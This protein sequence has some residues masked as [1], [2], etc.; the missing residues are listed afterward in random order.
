MRIALLAGFCFAGLFTSVMTFADASPALVFC[1]KPENDLARV[2]AECGIAFTRYDTPGQT[3]FSAP[4]HAGV[5]FL[6]DEYPAKTVF[7]APECF[8]TAAQK[9]LRLY[10]EYPAALPDM[11]VEPPKPLG[12]ERLV[13]TSGFFG[14]ALPPMRIAQINAGYIAGITA[15]NPLL[16]AAKVA[17]VDTAVFGLENTPRMPALFEHPSGRILVGTVKLSHFV[18]GRYAPHDAWASIWRAV[19]TWLAPE[20]EIP[21]LKWAPTVR[22]SYSKEEPLPPDAETMALT[23]AAAWFDRS[24]VFRHSGWPREALDWALTYNTV[25][26]RPADT[27]PRG[28]G[29]LGITEGYSSA[30]RLDGSQ[31]M[32]YAVRNDCVSEAAMTLAFDSVIHGAAPCAQKAANL[33]D[34]LYGASV[35]SQGTQNDPSSPM[36]GLIGWSLDSPEKFWGDDNARGMLAV[37]ATASLLQE[38]RWNGTL[39]RCLLAN[40]RTSGR[41]GFREGCVTGENLLKR[42]WPFFE[43]SDFKLYSA[44][45]DGWL[46]ACFLR[47]YAL[48]GYTPFLEKS[49]MAIAML[50]AAYPEHWEWVIRSAQIERARALLPLAWLVRAEDTP[51][52]RDWL[53][54]VAADLIAAQDACGAIRETLGGA[55]QSAASNAEYGTG[56]IT[57]LQCNGAPL[58]DSLYTCNF[59]LLGLHEAYAATGEELYHEAEEKLARFLCRIQIRSGTHPELDGAWYR[60]FDFGRWEFWASN[61][62]WEWGAWCIESGWSTPWIASALALRHLRTTLWELTNCRGL[63]TA[64]EQYRGAMLSES[65]QLPQSQ[66]GAL[67][68]GH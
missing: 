19:L 39:A 58:C 62:D 16:V 53:R 64:V 52:H 51:E 56:E 45:Y 12:L 2:A 25:R 18:T 41:S 4:E 65:K 32:R 43:N 21:E 60:G 57:L 33:I 17:G 44:H 66:S 49:K 34:Y 8:E 37:M 28:D 48:T 36:Y 26:D 7:V 38:P 10:I 42:G 23:R 40:L 24:G 31:P 13:V 55:A 68:G 50:M 22:P 1:C 35:M 5:L 63:Q 9:H 20:R 67:C 30:I 29:S 46:W 59:A 3:V 61:A 54:K 27:W 11:M 6:A 14:E 15:P 47:A